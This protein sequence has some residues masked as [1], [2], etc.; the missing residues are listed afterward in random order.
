MC[1]CLRSTK[2]KN[3]ET[4]CLQKQAHTYQNATGD[5][6][7]TRQIVGLELAVGGVLNE[8]WLVPDGGRGCCV[9][10]DHGD[11]RFL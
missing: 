3:Q 10:V 6:H 8:D 11:C 4:K 7:L 9:V 1:A 2:N 5:S